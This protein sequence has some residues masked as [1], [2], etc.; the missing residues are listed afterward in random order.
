VLEELGAEVIALGAAPNG[1]NINDGVGALHPES[2]ARAVRTY[3]ADLG[4]ALDGDADRVVMVDEQSN[5]IDGDQ[6]IGMCALDLRR[7]GRLARNTVVGTVMSNLGFELALRREGIQL[8]RTDVGDRYVVEA[9]R[10]EKLNLGGEQS[11][12]VVFLD[13][14]TTGDGLLTALQVLALLRRAERPLSQLASVFEPLPQLVRAVRVR[15]KPPLESLAGFQSLVGRLDDA[16]GERGRILVRYSG[17][18]SVARVM[19]EGDDRGLIE[20][21]CREICAYLHRELGEVS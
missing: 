10:R 11:G 5:V 20:E 16:L 1:V 9:M 21:I 7:Q 13:Y 6:L 18:E 14:N 19:V 12:H 15:E 4:I 3:R 17:T 2:M 8:I